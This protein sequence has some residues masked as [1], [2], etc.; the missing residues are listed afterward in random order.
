MTP[1]TV[2]I[3]EAKREVERARRQFAS[4]A[5]ALQYRLKPAN[6]MSSAWDGVREK[7]GEMADDAIETVKERPVAASGILAGIVLF[8]AREPLWRLASGFLRQD[9]EDEVDTG[10]IRADLDHHDKEYDLTA[11]IVKRS[12]KEGV[13]V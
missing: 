9:E 12:K 3:E 5:G 10:T 8:L 6:L 4:T 1:E 7:S 13:T 2:L 11:P